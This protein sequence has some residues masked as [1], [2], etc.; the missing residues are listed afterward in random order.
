[1]NLSVPSSAVVA[2]TTNPTVELVVHYQHLHSSD[3]HQ[4]SPCEHLF[5]D[6]RVI[7]LSTPPP[8]HVLKAN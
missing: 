8:P 3:L 6:Q 1:M 5:Q 4:T 2:L 7:R